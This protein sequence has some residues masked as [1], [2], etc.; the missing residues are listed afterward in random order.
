MGP[1]NLVDIADKG[2]SNL[3]VNL[4]TPASPIS[5]YDDLPSLGLSHVSL[6]L[7]EASTSIGPC[8]VLVGG[9]FRDRSKPS[10]LYCEG[11]G[12]NNSIFYAQTP[13]RVVL[14]TLQPSDGKLAVEYVYLSD[15]EP[16]AR[17]LKPPYVNGGLVF[18][19]DGEV[20][21]PSALEEL[22]EALDHLLKME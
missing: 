9:N 2:A 17:R 4:T 8:I 10:I 3:G 14:A 11:S 12:E 13:D 22:T 21:D 7:L 20:A 6:H 15:E 5:L 18:G 1:N 16:K 19:D